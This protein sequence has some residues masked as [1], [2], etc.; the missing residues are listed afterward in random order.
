MESVSCL[1]CGCTA[2]KEY[3]RG[4][5][6]LHHLPGE[7]RLVECSRCR[8]V[9][10]SPRPT[11][12]E[13]GRYYPDDYK[14]YRPAVHEEKSALRRLDRRFGLRRRCGVIT[15]FKRSGTLLDVGCGTGDFLA[16]MG[17]I[18]G[19]EVRGLEPHPRAA[20]WARAKYGLTVD[21]VSLDEARYPAGSFDAITL[22]DVL[23]HLPH[24]REA[25][26]RLHDLLRPTGIIMLA[27]PNR[28]SVDARLFGP[29]WAGLDVPRHFSVFSPPELAGVL[30]RVGFGQQWLLNLNGGYHSFALSCHFWL[31]GEG[32]ARGVAGIALRLVDSLPFRLATLPYFQTLAW[33]RRGAT[34]I[35][36]AQKA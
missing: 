18:P 34:M 29:F 25:L 27:L 8:F 2:A 13:I 3:R 31:E 23:E 17:S 16:A 21:Q 1:L 12:D 5:D 19:W 26:E 14:S 22:W 6:R 4:S 11:A 7:F 36:V 10:L 35:V 30:T 28:T 15:R 32:P 33:L 24:P 20:E 9:Y